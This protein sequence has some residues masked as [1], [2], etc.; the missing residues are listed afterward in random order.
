MA[1]GEWRMSVGVGPSPFTRDPVTTTSCRPSA[2]IVVVEHSA[3]ARVSLVALVALVEGWMDPRV[4][5][6]DLVRALPLSSHHRRRR[7]G[8]TR[9][10][11][12]TFGV[13]RLVDVGR[14]PPGSR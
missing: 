1:K 11:K 8:G 13:P 7:E 12:D 6:I 5:A 2:Q 3:A 9:P 10:R 4:S 14:A